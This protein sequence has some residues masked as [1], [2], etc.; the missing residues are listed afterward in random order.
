M[1]YRSLN[2]FDGVAFGN[3]DDLLLG[4]QL[5]T[6]LFTEDLVE[7]ILSFVGRIV[8]IFVGIY[9]IVFLII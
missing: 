9:Y 7:E 2:F 6:F 5:C 3:D 4:V 1:V 8:Y